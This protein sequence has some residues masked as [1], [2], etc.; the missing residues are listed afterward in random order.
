MAPNQQF[1]PHQANGRVAIVYPANK[2][3]GFEGHKNEKTIPAKEIWTVEDISGPSAPHYR[4]LPSA[5]DSTYAF[6][7]DREIIDEGAFYEKEGKF[8]YSRHKD[9]G[10]KKQK[11]NSELREAVSENMVGNSS[12]C[13][14]QA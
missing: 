4:K 7:N 6:S 9:F 2:I 10:R 1:D 5:D 12:A 13:H 14:A 11:N 3:Q 8:S